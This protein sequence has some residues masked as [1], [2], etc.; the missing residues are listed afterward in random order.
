MTHFGAAR[1]RIASRKDT[2]YYCEQL[3][4]GGVGLVPRHRRCPLCAHA[5]AR[6]QSFAAPH[7]GVIENET[8]GLYLPNV[9]AALDLIEIATADDDV[10]DVAVFMGQL[11]EALTYDELN[12]FAPHVGLGEV[13]RPEV[14]LGRCMVGV[15]E[16]DENIAVQ[17]VRQREVLA[18]D[19]DD[20]LGQLCERSLVG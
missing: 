2:Q 4:V 9:F 10:V 7:G 15:D 20:H 12:L 5:L 13:K 11:L 6:K 16:V 17:M 1:P 19:A 3:Y 8:P 18:H 14:D